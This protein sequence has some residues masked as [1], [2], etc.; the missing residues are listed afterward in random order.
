MT[1]STFACLPALHR[2]IKGEKP[3]EHTELKTK[4]RSPLLDRARNGIPLEGYKPIRFVRGI[5]LHEDDA[6]LQLA[7]PPEKGAPIKVLSGKKLLSENQAFAE[8]EK[9]FPGI[10]RSYHKASL[11]SAICADRGGRPP[12]VVAVGPTGSGKGETIRLA[13]SFLDDDRLTLALVKDEEKMFRRIGSAVEAGRRFLSFDEFVRQG[14]MLP[15]L[16]LFCLQ[17]SSSITWRRLFKS[18]EVQTRNRAA[19]FLTAGCVP[20]GFKKSPEIRRRMW[21]ARLLRQVPEWAKTCGEDTGDWRALLVRN[22]QIA[23]SILTH[24]YALCAEYD[25]KFDAVAEKLGLVRIDEGEAELQHEVLRELYRHC[26]N[27]NDDRVLHPAER[28][29]QGRW[30]DALS[31]PCRELLQQLVPDED[32][33]CRDAAGLIFQLQQNLQMVPWNRVLGFDDPPI[34]CEMRRHGAKVVIR[35]REANCKLR[36]EHRIN[37]SLPSISDTDGEDYPERLRG[38]EP[39]GGP[40]G[41]AENGGPFHQQCQKTWQNTKAAGGSEPRK[42]DVQ[43]SRS[44]SYAR[45]ASPLYIDE[46]KEKGREEEKEGEKQEYSAKNVEQL[47]D[48]DCYPA[49]G[50]KEEEATPGMRES[51]DSG[52]PADPLQWPQEPGLVLGT[53]AHVTSAAQVDHRPAQPGRRRGQEGP[54]HALDRRV[55]RTPHPGPAP[56]GQRSRIPC[57]AADVAGQRGL[58]TADRRRKGGVGQPTTFFRHRGP[59]DAPDPHR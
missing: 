51:L 29:R 42:N 20:D 45:S 54:I 4:L 58:S 50:R 49:R 46:G 15:T 23:N 35:F 34:L 40:N 17:P 26:Q 27:K 22:G 1:D 52:E 19:Y 56:T 14:K 48:R 24:S 6:C 36:G 5:V 21:L 33:D 11:A 16:I 32:T 30:V 12:I 53:P 44:A 31:G 57:P 10:D 41:G 55:R 8:L 9:S 3:D 28:F 37:E 47:A 18:P 13:A 7:K 2:V 39:T 38:G 43:C 25:F 59:G